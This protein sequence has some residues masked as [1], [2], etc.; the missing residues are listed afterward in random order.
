MTSILAVVAILG[1]LLVGAISPGPSFVVI[2]RLSVAMS[3]RH[4]VAASLG[5]GVGGVVF[6]GLA[7][8]GLHIVLAQVSWLYLSLKVLGGLYLVYLAV[9]MWRG[10]NDPIDAA[11]PIAKVGTGLGKAFLYGLSVQIANPK[12]AVVYGSVFAALLPPD[13]TMSATAVL[14]PL[15]FAIEA[16]WY[17]AVALVFSSSRPRLAYLRFKKWVDRAAGSVM[18]TLGLRL[19]IEARRLS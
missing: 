18:A 3:R 14:L 7:L 5:M 4:G 13:M 11:Q 15:I 12:T 17:S 16:G 8:L 6:A 2:A 9:R 10:A 19:I 1:A